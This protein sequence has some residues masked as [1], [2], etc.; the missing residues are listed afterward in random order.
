M[1]RMLLLNLLGFLF[2]NGWTYPQSIE[3]KIQAAIDSIYAANPT[4][5]GIMLHIESPEKGIS[6]SAASGYSDKTTKI[7]LEADQPAL[8][9]SNIKTY[10]SA[11]ILRL[12]EEDKLSINTPIKGLIS[13]KTR[14]LFEKGGY[15]LDSIMVKHLL[16]HT[17]GIN[18]YANQAY[19][20]FINNNKNY[21][22]TRDEQLE[23][24]IKVGTPINKPGELF[25]YSDTNYLLLTEI[26]ENIVKQPFYIVMRELL[27]YESM[28]LNDTWMPTLEEKPSRTKALV[29]QYWNEY[30]WDSYEIDISTDLYGGGGLAST[31]KDL[32]CFAYKLF[33]T[34]IIKDS[35]VL[36]LIFTEVPT[37]VIQPGKYYFGL[38][39]YEYQG[40]AAYGHSGFWGT[41]ILY[42]PRLKTS[43]AIFI[44]EKDQSDITE[45]IINLIITFMN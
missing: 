31:T 27:Q 10:V 42:F 44:L 24:A 23:L 8:I 14:N 15:N 29:H 19:D 7:I 12:V 28:G 18:N 33:N 38:S 43:I 1:K 30:N 37:K 35:T 22:W 41:K 21:R 16:S 2:L 39:S 17:S 5:I 40:F 36:N 9:A 4:S 45:D 20:D 3:T 26:I 32:A 25:K 11:T 13:E 34:K 6:L